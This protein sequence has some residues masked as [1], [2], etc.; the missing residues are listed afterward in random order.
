MSPGGVGAPGLNP[1]C[2]FRNTE[3][4]FF[5]HPRTVARPAPAGAAAALL[6]P[7]RREEAGRAGA[8]GSF[9]DLG[10]KPSSLPLASCWQPHPSEA[11]FLHLEMRTRRTSCLMMRK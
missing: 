6:F 8:G 7:L 10:A 2:C 9:L 3:A 4:G 1:L 11:G 5:L